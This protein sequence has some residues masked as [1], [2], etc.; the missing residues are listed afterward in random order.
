[1]FGPTTPK[2]L[3]SYEFEIQDVIEAIVG[4][5]YGQII[6]LGCAEGY[7]AVGLAWRIPNCRVFAFDTDPLCR[8]QTRRLAALNNLSGRVTVQG[9]CS[10]VD[11]ERLAANH[12]LFLIDIEGDE[13][14]LLDP[15]KAPAIRR[16]DIL[17]E[18]HE[19]ARSNGLET[20]ESLLRNRFETS[21]TIERRI[22]SDGSAWIQRNSQAW[23]RRLTP[24]EVRN[25]VNEYRTGQQIWLWMQVRKRPTN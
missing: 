3:G 20:S 15:A 1:M 10:H 23:H 6:N 12:S 17:V 19:A 5:E 9:R 24:V 22:P 4:C 7:Y 8:M 11:I 2:W 13:A 25:A 16:A 21:H 18:V 14:H